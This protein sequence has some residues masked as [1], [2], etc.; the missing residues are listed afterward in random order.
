MTP[1]VRSTPEKQDTWDCETLGHALEVA[2][3]LEAIGRIMT[4]LFGV[5]DHAVDN[6]G[7]PTETQTE[8]E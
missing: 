4:R 7:D 5:A 8:E 6:E 3:F 1:P 2:N